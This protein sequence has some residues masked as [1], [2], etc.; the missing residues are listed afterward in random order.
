[1]TVEGARLL[2]LQAQYL[3]VRRQ[4]LKIAEPLSAEDQ[5][6]Q[7]MEDASPTKW[8]LAHTTWFVEATILEPRLPGYSKFSPWFSYLFNSYYESLGERQ[9]RAQRGHL[10]RPSLAEVLAYRRYVDDAVEH[11]LWTADPSSQAAVCES[12]ALGI[13]HEQQHQELMLTDALHVTWSQPVPSTYSSDF[14]HFPTVVLARTDTWLICPGGQV[15]IGS[16]PERFS[17]D[18]ERPRHDVLLQPFQIAC[19]LVTNQQYADF[20]A[21]GGYRR[22]DLWLSDGWAAVQRE[23]RH[24]PLYWLSGDD[25]RVRQ[26]YPD[27]QSEAWFIHTLEGLI[28]MQPDAPVSN[29][30]Y[31]E[32]SAYAEWAQARLPTEFEWEA[33]CSLAGMEQTT[34]WVWQWTRSAYLPYPGFRP[35]PGVA[36]EYNGKFMV[37]QMVLRGGS[38]ATSDQHTR[39]AYRNFFP[40]DA[41]W[42]FT[43]IRLA[44]D[45]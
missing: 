12:L 7:S 30:N 29:V 15:S 20:I 35:N 13:Q 16:T 18:N 3:T 19:G 22:A 37:N 14:S 17:Y 45:L 36:A 9:P 32:A 27:S 43:G 41:R 2:E 1:M 42:Q 26:I 4:S 5:M 31:F 8:H 39:P 23:R 6:V 44:R 34:G 40:P 10:S 25:W 33:A 21:D 28:P 24:A 38:F 11:L